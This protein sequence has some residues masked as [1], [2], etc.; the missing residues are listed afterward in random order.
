M[1][2]DTAK[3]RAE[4]VFDPSKEYGNLIHLEESSEND[5]ALIERL[6]KSLKKNASVVV[7]AGMKGFIV[8]AC[9]A[10]GRKGRGWFYGP[11]WRADAWPSMAK[12]T[13]FIVEGEIA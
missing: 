1:N 3:A 10:D 7:P 6:D 12:V 5:S 13:E 2:L 4:F 9:D 8:T 11:K